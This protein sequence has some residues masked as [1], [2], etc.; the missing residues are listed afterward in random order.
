MTQFAASKVCGQKIHVLI[1][2][3]PPINWMVKMFQL[4]YLACSAQN[5][6]KLL[7]TN[8]LANFKREEKRRDQVS[9][10]K[11][12]IRNYSAHNQENKRKRE[13]IFNHLFPW[14]SFW[15]KLQRKFLP[16]PCSRPSILEFPTHLIL[17]ELCQQHQSAALLVDGW[18]LQKKKKLIQ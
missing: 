14:A 16:L 17:I 5:L 4:I 8:Q 3:I 15:I 18:T 7:Y 9:R 12:S 10:K 6:G 1:P 2:L 11:K 13:G